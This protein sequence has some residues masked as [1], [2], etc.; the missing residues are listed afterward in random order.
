MR[1]TSYREAVQSEKADG[2]YP[3]KRI[4]GT[5]SAEGNESDSAGFHL[6]QGYL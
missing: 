3:G 4:R 2:M 1:A 6:E 5:Y